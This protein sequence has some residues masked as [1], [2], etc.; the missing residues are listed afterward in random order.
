M[1]TFNAI[2]V[3]D[4][5]LFST[6]ANAESSVQYSLATV[7]C[8][9]EN[10]D[11]SDYKGN[12]S[13][14]ALVI[15]YPAV[16]HVN[17]MM[18][19]SKRLASRGTIV[20]FVTTH[21][22]HSHMMKSQLA[23]PSTDLQT[24]H[25]LGL[26][27]RPAQISDGLPLEF[28]RSANFNEFLL[29]MDR[30]VEAE[31]EKLI[32]NLN[33]ASSDQLPPLSFIIADAFHP[34]TLHVANK[35]GL[36]WVVLWPEAAASY[37]I[38]SKWDLL[39]SQGH[40]PLRKPGAVERN[41][42]IDCIPDIPH[43]RATELPDFMHTSNMTSNP[44]DELSYRT[45]KNVGEAD[46]VLCNSFSELESRVIDGIQLKSPMC[47][48]GPLLP[49]DDETDSTHK[50]IVGRSLFWDVEYWLD[51][52][53]SESVIYVSFGS[54][55]HMSKAQ[56]QEIAVGL[57]Q[58]QEFF[59]WILRPDIVAS[60]VSDV[61]PQGFMEDTKDQGLVLPWCPQLEVLSHPCV[62][63]F[64]TH[65]GWNS[66]MESLSFGVPMLGLPLWADQY[67]NCKLISDEWRIGLKMMMNSGDGVVRRE[68]IWKG[69]K[70]LMKGEEGKEM[71]RRANILRHMAK[72]A[73][74]KGGS[75][76]E[77]INRF[78][79]EMENRVIGKEI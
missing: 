4:I 42:L 62:G 46:W 66:V 56:V 25:D 48:V 9:L 53:P 31:I 75:S 27:I 50:S 70:M 24:D 12:G 10:G 1:P 57:Q 61:L 13:L 40:L 2:A 41:D 11:Q 51:T 7:K 30:N 58:S 60:N 17:P 8:R 28:D 69:V 19:L 74:L 5:N 36:P 65:C 22:F 77:N 6:S 14:H 43:L 73:L 29:S 20:T 15:P 67:L 45:I 44:I 23:T 34:Q 49:F 38:C 63:G 72:G 52:K 59:V 33:A 21:A 26:H 37:S 78:L 35:L 76:Y 71:K 16:G 79:K 32:L 47:P 54:T 64:L 55:A 3:S 18:H 39:L 68:E